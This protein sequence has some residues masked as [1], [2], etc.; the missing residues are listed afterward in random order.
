[1]DNG[2]CCCRCGEVDRRSGR[3]KRAASLRRPGRRASVGLL[4]ALRPVCDGARL[5]FLVGVV[6]VLRNAMR[7]SLLLLLA[8]SVQRFLLVRARGKPSI[9]GG[10][11]RNSMGA[12]RFVQVVR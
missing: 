12:G 6:L 1:M 5:S 9:K 10:W 3:P 11:S 2:C 4:L 8:V 7:R